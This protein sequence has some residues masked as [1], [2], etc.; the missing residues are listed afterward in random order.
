MP[1]E[2]PLIR[3]LHTADAARGAPAPRADLAERAYL[4]ARR[5]DARARVL[6]RTALGAG[7]VAALLLAVV[8]YRGSVADRE[9]AEVPVA[10]AD[11]AQIAQLR[12]EAEAFR[13]QADSLERTL[14]AA[15]NEVAWQEL[16][17]E[18][19]RQTALAVAAE[20]TPS[21]SD[22]AASI[23]LCEGDYYRDTAGEIDA[24]VAAY[25]RVVNRFPDSPL[26]N[27]A[28]ERLAGIEMN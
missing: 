12:A 10:A 4:G 26:A 27:V 17:D 25:Q 28:R 20:V 8:A 19:R 15:R 3:L 11:S 23:A 24:A 18:S 14:S 16:L 2:D 9:V 22:R 21:G 13:A 7:A 5:K 1:H 6:R